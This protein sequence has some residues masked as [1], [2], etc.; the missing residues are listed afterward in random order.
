MSA[1]SSASS[2]GIKLHVTAGR[3]SGAVRDVN[4]E[5]QFIGSSL[6]AN[7]VLTD[8]GV[9]PRH[10]RID[11]SRWGFELE[12]LDGAVLVN[13]SSLQPGQR[14]QARYPSTVAVGDAQIEIVRDQAAQRRVIAS[15]LFVGAL[16]LLALIIMADWHPGASENGSA[17]GAKFNAASG[18]APLQHAVL[19]GA[20]ATKTAVDALRRHL[21][22]QGL[23]AIDVKPG[24]GTVIVTGSIVPERQGEWQSAE[25]WFDENFGQNIMLQSDVSISPAKPVKAPITIQSVWLGETPYLIDGEGRKYFEGSILKGG[26]VLE[27]VG[28]DRILISKDKQPLILRY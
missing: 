28:E 20:E 4:G 18:V 7:L 12:A 3:H 21:L 1:L 26:W 6:D 22:L 11:F 14:T 27:K 17:S 25:M 19:A 8:A 16:G 13:G 23:G 2:S 15:L 9:C 24:A 5:P 10:A